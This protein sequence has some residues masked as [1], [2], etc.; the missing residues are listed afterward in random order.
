MSGYETEILLSP[1]FM[2]MS[3]QCASS[4]LPREY[5]EERFLFFALDSLTKS[6]DKTL[7]RGASGGRVSLVFDAILNRHVAAKIIRNDPGSQW[8][9]N[10]LA[11]ASTRLSTKQRVIPEIYGASEVY[12]GSH[13]A[14]YMQLLKPIDFNEPGAVR[15]YARGMRRCVDTLHSIGIAHG[16]I[17]PGNFM[18]DPEAQDDG[19]RIIDFGLAFD[20]LSHY[21]EAPASPRGWR[22]PG[23]NFAFLPTNV[24]KMARDFHIDNIKLEAVI[25]LLSA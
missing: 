8:E 16:D 17:H 4:P 13:V 11:C 15:K 3:P 19:V 12:A 20:Y 6:E 1:S 25:D 10:M 14:I 22:H 7:G 18:W 9:I 24:A 23:L 2:L 5:A 21:S